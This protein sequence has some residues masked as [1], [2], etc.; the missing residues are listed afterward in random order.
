MNRIKFNRP[1]HKNNFTSVL[2]ELFNKNFGD[3]LDNDFSKKSPAINIKES[4]SAFII[5]LA[6]PGLK[7]E[8]FNI[9]VEKDQLIISSKVES[10]EAIED[11]VENTKESVTYKRREFNYETFRK[12]FHIN[13]DIDLTKINAKYEDGILTVSLEKRE[14]AKAQEPRRITVA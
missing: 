5:E 13:K 4:E 14:E 12:S 2:D 6:A 11:N 8:N 9:N 7:K 1:V 10:E 3:V